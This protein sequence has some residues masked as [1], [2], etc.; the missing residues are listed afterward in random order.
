MRHLVVPEDEHVAFG[1]EATGDR[2]DGEE[3]VGASGP[4]GPL[5][6][7]R[8]RAPRGRA[9][10]AVED[11]LASGQ[12][13]HHVE[14]RRT[15]PCTVPGSRTSRSPAPGRLARREPAR[16]A[17][18]EPDDPAAGG[19]GAQHAPLHAS[20]SATRTSACR[21]HGRACG[22]TEC[23]VTITGASTASRCRARVGV[24]E[25]RVLVLDV[26]QPQS[27]ARGWPGSHAH[28]ARQR[29][30]QLG[31]VLPDP[32]AP[33]P[34][35]HPYRPRPPQRPRRPGVPLH[36]V[37]DRRPHRPDIPLPHRPVRRRLV[38]GRAPPGMARDPAEPGRDGVDVGD[39]GHAAAAV[40]GVV[41]GREALRGDRQHPIARLPADVGL[42]LAVEG[43]HRQPGRHA[44]DQR[45][46]EALVA[47]CEQDIGLPVPAG[48][49]AS[50]LVAV[51]DPDARVG[52]G[53]TAGPEARLD[54]Q[55]G[56]WVVPERL[57][58]GGD[59]LG[60][61]LAS[62]QRPDR[63]A[64]SSRPARGAAGSRGWPDRR[65]RGRRPAAR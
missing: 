33:L 20:V 45:Q 6:P 36:D 12:C 26:Q 56:P 21:S 54:Q 57:T 11:Q 47:E 10:V 28:A 19:A 52:A 8:S 43:D 50:R 1:G 32:A 31:G 9:R 14:Q 30:Y 46:P 15:S 53:Q 27:V 49:A 7:W 39:G 23:S 65:R 62:D 55:A 58:P 18:P 60:E 37:E 25:Q 42:A 41:E 22:Q 44:L 38:P 40:A 51:D 16:A 35:G 24:V 48:Q 64:S 13:A 17:M 34:A 3:F 29:P 59:R 5:R 4:A 63:P 2:L 61:V